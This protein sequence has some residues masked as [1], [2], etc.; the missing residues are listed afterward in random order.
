MKCAYRSASFDSF[1]SLKV[2]KATVFLY[3]IPVAV[4]VPG[5]IIIC[6]RIAKSSSI[7]TTTNENAARERSVTRSLIL[8]SAAYL[9]TMT[10]AVIYQNLVH[11][12]VVTVNLGVRIFVA[13]L[14]NINASINFILYMLQGSRFRKEVKELFC[15]CRSEI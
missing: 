8:I 6:R 4:I 13:L 14:S 15:C 7:R 1:Y 5:N 2:K 9:I 10:P 11:Y 3:I 12:E